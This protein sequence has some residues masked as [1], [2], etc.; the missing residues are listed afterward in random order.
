VTG[1]AG[2]DVVSATEAGTVIGLRSVATVELVTAGGLGDVHV[3]GSAAANTLN[4]GS[5]TLTSIV[6]VDG[7]DGGD[8]LTGTT[9]DDVVLG[10]AGADTIA[11]GAGDDT[12][13]GGAGNDGLTGGSGADRFRFAAGFGSDTLTAFDAAP[14]GGQD[15]LDVSPLGITA[16][17]FAASVTIEAGATPGS[18]RVRI[19]TAVIALPGVAPAAVT[20]ADFTLAPDSGARSAAPPAAGSGSAL[21]PTPATARATRPSLAGV[22][23]TVT[24]ATMRL[25]CAV[26]CSGS[27]RAFAVPRRSHAAKGTPLATR[28]FRAEAGTVARVALRF[29][30]AARRAV[31]RAGRV[32]VVVTAAG[33]TRTVVVSVRR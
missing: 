2:S 9:A 20:M 26:A 22:R 28:R 19:G 24:G 5:M 27:A 12:V 17:T 15:T 33:T 14:A 13:T 23:A 4:L 10:S 21:S 11:G 7:A 18:T 31:R 8:T 29:G 3:L 32:R 6:D 30:A 1:A 16:A 25:T